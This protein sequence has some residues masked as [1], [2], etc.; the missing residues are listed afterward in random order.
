MSI[1]FVS[2]EFNTSDL[3]LNI[4]VSAYDDHSDMRMLL[5]EIVIHHFIINILHVLMHRCMNRINHLVLV[6]NR[7]EHR[8]GITVFRSQDR[9]STA[10]R[11]CRHGFNT[12]IFLIEER[13]PFWL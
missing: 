5:R 4:A 6:F 2:C 7:E 10:E 8:K 9:K 12:D 11:F 1:F 13:A 3:L